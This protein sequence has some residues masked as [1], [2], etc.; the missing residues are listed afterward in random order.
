MSETRRDK[1]TRAIADRCFLR[2]RVYE[3]EA[4]IRELEGVPGLSDSDLDVFLDLVASILDSRPDDAF[5]TPLGIRTAL[6][7]VAGEALCEL[8][9][10]GWRIA[11]PIGAGGTPEG[12]KP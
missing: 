6:L 10:Q 5:A 9:E 3:L 4:R 11:S 8:A 12:D 1:L 2:A 7:A